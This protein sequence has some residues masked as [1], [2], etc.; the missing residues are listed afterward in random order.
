MPRVCPRLTWGGVT[1][2]L[3]AG[4]GLGAD[5]NG[6]PKNGVRYDSPTWCG[7]SVSGGYAEDDTVDVAVRYAADWNNFKV[8]AAY[9]FSETTDEGCSSRRSPALASAPAACFSLTVFGGGGAP[10]Q[11]FATGCHGQPGRRLGLACPDRPVHLW[12]VSEGGEQRN[13]P[14]LRLARLWLRLT[15][16][17]DTDV[18]YVK[19]GIKRTWTPLG[20]T[21]LFGEGGQ[22]E[23]QFPVPWC[24][25]WWEPAQPLRRAQPSRWA[26][27]CVTNTSLFMTDSKVDRW[28]AG[29]VQEIDAAAM[30]VWFN[31]QHLEFEGDFAG[32]GTSPAT[33]AATST[34][35][36][37]ASIIWIC[38][39]LVA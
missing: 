27:V 31:W 9:G 5:C 36:T 2:C 29:I 7:F 39:W 21:V 30:H 14:Y 38:S 32:N 12:H 8:S 11:G 3:E 20:A 23:H 15:T 37:R 1:N 17:N 28:G 35:S 6:Y 13:V 25:L 16:L 19:A 26:V 34:R 24:D 33:R 18:W 10:F 4:G 22:Y